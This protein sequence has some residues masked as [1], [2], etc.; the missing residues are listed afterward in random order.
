MTANT[1]FPVGF[2]SMMNP[3]SSFELSSQ[4]NSSLEAEIENFRT[5]PGSAGP[6]PSESPLPGP[7]GELLLPHPVSETATII[8]DI[9]EINGL[10]IQNPPKVA[11][12][13]GGTQNRIQPG[14]M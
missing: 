10:F 8:Q 9:Q 13:P 5:F 2:R 1:L 7:E 4:V 6:F 3:S 14:V 12:I 11:P